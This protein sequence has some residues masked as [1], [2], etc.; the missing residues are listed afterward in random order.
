[1][2]LWW[3]Q[4]NQ[5]DIHQLELIEKL[6]LQESWL[7]VGPP[8]SGKTNV[9]L[10]RA[11]FVRT[12]DMPNV[13]V[14]TFTRALV[15][16]VKTGCYDAEN[17]EIFPEALVTTIESWIRW[18]YA[19]HEEQLPPAE[20]DLNIWKQR[21]AA[22]A[23]PFQRRGRVP[24]YDALFIDEAQDLLPEEVALLAQW[25]SV[26]FV[27]GDDRQRI[28]AGLDG[29]PEVRKIILASHEKALPFHYRIAPEICRMA[30]RIFVPTAGKSLA[31]TE[32]YQGPSPATIDIQERPL[33]KTEQMDLMAAKLKDQIRVY[34]DLL[35]AGDKLGIIVARRDDRDVVF[36][37]LE[38]DPDLVG[39]SKVIRA[40][41]E[42]E[43]G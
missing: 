40:R 35:K 6:P 43:Q 1:M 20:N 33:G 11:Q 37:H 36:R 38:A 15:E 31:S 30:D 19:Q 10:R 42:G 13:L 22:G 7:I 27:V 9:L 2:S 17:R 18:L 28:F 14:L 3:V 32:H 8:G 25:S 39:R 41:D 26:L 23:L 24:K 4:K 16:F 12:Q 21:L 5:L 34:A 29:L